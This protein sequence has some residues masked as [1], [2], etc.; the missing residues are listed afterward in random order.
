M[1][2]QNPQLNVKINRS[3]Y[4][5]SG[6][7]GKSSLLLLLLTAFIIMPLAAI[8]YAYASWFV[9]L[10][11]LAILLT[12]G[13]SFFISWI[14]SFL[15][16]RMGKVRNKTITILFSLLCGSIALYVAWI[17]WAVLVT[18]SGEIIGNEHIG[19]I[20]SN[21][22]IPD[23]IAM[24]KHPSML[25][26]VID[27][28]KTEGIWSLP[29]FKGQNINGI[30][31]VIFWCIEVILI[32]GLSFLKPLEKSAQPFSEL[33]NQWL[34]SKT[35]PRMT[36]V[37]NLDDVLNLTHEKEEDNF[38]FVRQKNAFESYTEVILYGTEKS[39]KYTTIISYK[40]TIN[41]RGE[42]AFRPLTIAYQ[43]SLNE[44]E[45]T[46]LNELTSQS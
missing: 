2:A 28:V 25:F 33:T 24:I 36:Y 18:N 20:K 13:F 40:A 43:I 31:L 17:T 26:W 29:F 35:S 34:S 45:F 4:V 46:R 15:I 32:L 7:I 1:N 16:I 5:P 10:V 6:K 39:E 14:I 44:D 38:I 22:P 37:E 23:L 19:I 11:Y 27:H 9:P 21:T 42:K 3:N 30:L 41:G 12:I 8:L